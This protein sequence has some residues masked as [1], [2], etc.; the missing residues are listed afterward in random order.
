ME[1]R[2]GLNNLSFEQSRP[3]LEN[4]VSCGGLIPPSG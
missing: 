4:P 2:L 3:V 1:T